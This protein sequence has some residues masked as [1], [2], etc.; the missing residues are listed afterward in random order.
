[1]LPFLLKILR[2][3]LLLLG[4]AVVMLWLL[5][6]RTH[7]WTAQLDTRATPDRIFREITDP[8]RLPMWMSEVVQVDPL[9]ELPPQVGSRARIMTKGRRGTQEFIDSEI[10]EFDSERML[11]LQL[12]APRYDASST[13]IIERKGEAYQLQ[14][15]LQS[16]Y[17]GLYRFMTP[18]VDSVVQQRLD[19]DFQ[20]LKELLEESIE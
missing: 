8:Q 1:M 12:T 6:G 17:K 4:I 13:F 10:V 14:Q 16:R 5:G 2:P 20:L 19:A 15:R 9:N 3:A 11:K 7:T 18:F